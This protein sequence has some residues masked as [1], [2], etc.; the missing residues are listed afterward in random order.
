MM[1]NPRMDLAVSVA[2]I[3]EEK[4]TRKQDSSH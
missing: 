3:P 4:W 1:E 2:C